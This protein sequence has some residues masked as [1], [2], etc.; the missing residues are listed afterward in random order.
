M[1]TTTTPTLVPR[2][3]W[4][5]AGND[6]LT[7]Y[8]MLPTIEARWAEVAAEHLWRPSWGR[9]CLAAVAGRPTGPHITRDCVCVEVRPLHILDHL[10]RW[11][12]ATGGTVLTAETSTRGDELTAALGKFRATVGARSGIT[13]EVGPRS[14]HNPGDCTLLIFRKG[15]ASTFPQAVV[16]DVKRSWDGVFL[17]YATCPHGKTVM[18]G[19]GSDPNG[20]GSYLTSRVAHARC[21]H[22]RLCSGYELTDPDGIVPVRVAALVE[23]TR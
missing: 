19:G 1:T 21:C 14:P 10:R 9:D 18:H 22:L 6:K 3:L 8:E 4:T 11:Q 5:K 16:C 13:V 20:I 17:I 15:T 7:R 12:T 23:E 2:R